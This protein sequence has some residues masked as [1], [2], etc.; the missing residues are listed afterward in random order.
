[1]KPGLKRT[2]ARRTRKYALLIG[3]ALLAAG[4]GR[5]DEATTGN[6]SAG[7]QESRPT[8][9]GTD[10]RGMPTGAT[11]VSV[12]RVTMGSIA[13][14]STV[15]GTVEPIRLVNVNSQLS[16]I[17]LSVNVQEGDQVKTGDLLAG[18]DDREISAQLAAAEANLEVAKASFER[19]QRL[20]DQNVITLPEFEKERTTL[21]AATASVDQLKTRL[22]F[23]RIKAPIAG[24]VTDKRVEQGDGV[25]PQTRLFTIAD[26]STLVVR[27]GVSEL[28]VGD[29]SRGDHVDIAMDALPGEMLGGSI[30]RI[31][32]T[33]DPT[34]RLVTVEVALDHN[35][36]IK[37]RPGF[38]ARI[39]FA[40][41]T[42]SGVLLVPATALIGAAGGQTVY[43][44][45]E[46]RA[47]RR[48]VEAGLTSGGM[49]EIVNGLKEGD[50]VVTAGN[51]M[52]RDGSQVRIIEEGDR[53]VP[54]P[55][56]EGSE[57]GRG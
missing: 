15:A 9:T 33:G 29:L 38:L 5:R 23:T 4:C 11:P 43:V 36:T 53:S 18:L 25:A 13:R 24:V 50:V 28:D 20:R 22:G 56:T 40:L 10:R 44:V 57:G 17:L 21:A 19:A 55:G 12:A 3:A 54:D 45:E 34:T 1:V 52:L 8:T 35:A 47:V 41:A 6:G 26:V 39:S 7:A 46:D 51:N 16:G 31:F 30:R 48:T 32:P 14:S 37:V 42:R 49:V 2:P 27:V